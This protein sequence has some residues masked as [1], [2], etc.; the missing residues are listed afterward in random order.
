MKLFADG[1]GFPANL[2]CFKDPQISDLSQNVSLLREVGFLS[3][4]RLYAPDEMNFGPIKLRHQV[5]NAFGKFAQKG[6]GRG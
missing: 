5:F 1:K 2:N 4:V 3:I 6:F